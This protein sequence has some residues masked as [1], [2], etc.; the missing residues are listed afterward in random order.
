MRCVLYGGIVGSI[1]SFFVLR[2]PLVSASRR[3]EP[4]NGGKLDMGILGLIRRNSDL[5]F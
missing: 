5:F 3:R 4:I 2:Q 1:A